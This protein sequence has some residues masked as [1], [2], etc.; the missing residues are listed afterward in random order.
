MPLV[1]VKMLEGRTL[2]QKKAMVEKVTQA[3]VETTGA[4]PDNV[5][6]DIVH[7]SREDFA[8]NGKLISEQ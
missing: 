6:I 5:L 3:I 7:M 8:R 1:T 4:E 2:E